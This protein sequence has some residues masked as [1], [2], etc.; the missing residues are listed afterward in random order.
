MATNPPFSS[1]ACHALS[2]GT[3]NKL[4]YKGITSRRELGV[5]K[6]VCSK[7]GST[8]PPPTNRVVPVNV[9][10]TILAKAQ[11]I[12]Q[13]RLDMAYDW[14]GSR[15]RSRM[16]EWAVGLLFFGWLCLILVAVFLVTR[17]AGS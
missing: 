7:L 10:V 12:Q 11:A 6:G 9:S 16:D 8:S 15:N 4:T 17:L 1:L 14:D 13:W 3:R 5:V 2:A